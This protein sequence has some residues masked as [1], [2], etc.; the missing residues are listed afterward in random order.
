MGWND[1][2]GGRK[3]WRGA[4]EEGGWKGSERGM[5]CSHWLV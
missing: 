4:F 1:R 5:I 3:G 2:D